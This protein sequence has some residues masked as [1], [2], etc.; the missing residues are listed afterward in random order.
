MK[1]HVLIIALLF[2]GICKQSSA[3]FDIKNLD[4]NNLNLKDIIG[5]VMKVEHGFSPKFFLGN[6]KIP[7]IPQVAQILGLKKNMQVIK[8]FNTFRTG[9]TIFHLA[10]YAGSAVA[11]YGIIKSAGDSSSRANYKGALVGGLTSALS[12]VI[13]KLLTKGAAYKAVDIFNGIAARKIKD[14]FSIRPASSTAGI[15]LYVKLD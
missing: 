12:G 1:K 5:K 3:Q 4:F 11:I 2:T 15:G 6:S 8:L 10:S 13:I 9:R 14:I 7:K